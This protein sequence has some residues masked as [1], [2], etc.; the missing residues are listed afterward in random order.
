MPD[1]GLENLRVVEGLYAYVYVPHDLEVANAQELGWALYTPEDEFYIPLDGNYG[2]AAKYCMYVTHKLRLEDVDLEEVELAKR[3]GGTFPLKPMSLERIDYNITRDEL[4]AMMVAKG[5]G[6]IRNLVKICTEY[7]S[8][9][10]GASMCYP[11]PLYEGM[12]HVSRHLKTMNEN[13]YLTYEGQNVI[14]EPND[15]YVTHRYQYLAFAFP[16]EHAEELKKLLDMM[17]PESLCGAISAAT[18]WSTGLTKLNSVWNAWF[19]SVDS[20]TYTNHETLEFLTSVPQ[21]YGYPQDTFPPSSFFAAFGMCAVVA[22][23]NQPELFA[24]LA[25]FAK[26][27]PGRMA[28]RYD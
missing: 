16:L 23:N 13:G 25:H 11:T 5:V 7:V 6:N 8:G 19:Y 10:I 28:V 20:G 24:N 21:M 26:I 27:H 17:N 14:H 9:Q 15:L 1:G 12:E 22:K 18:E 2:N 3:E 4:R